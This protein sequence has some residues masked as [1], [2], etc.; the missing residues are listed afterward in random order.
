MSW[1]GARHSFRA[2]P[3]DPDD[4]VEAISAIGAATSICPFGTHSIWVEGAGVVV[5]SFV[6]D[7][8]SFFTRTLAQGEH[9]GR[10]HHIQD[11]NTT[12]TGIEANYDDYT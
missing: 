7:P 9:E 11:T 12:A 4:A 2:V 10:F 5:F 1:T 3:I 8:T 6:G